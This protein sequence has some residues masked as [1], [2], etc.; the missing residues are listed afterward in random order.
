MQIGV[1]EKIGVGLCINCYLIVQ[2]LTGPAVTSFF[3]KLYL[4][5]KFY[6]RIYIFNTLTEL[7]SPMLLINDS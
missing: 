2:P 4:D 5:Y 3:K 1:E 7:H 6:F